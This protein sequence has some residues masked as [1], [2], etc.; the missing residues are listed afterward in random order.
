MSTEMISLLGFLGIFAAVLL[1]QPLVL[2]R[3]RGIQYVM[4]NRDDALGPDHPAVGRLART[5]SN[6]VEAAVLFIPLVLA[7]EVLGISNAL[8]QY[9][10]VAFLAARATYAVLYP[11]GVVGLRSLVW[12]AGLCALV[13]MAAGLIIA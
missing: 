6:N 3:A 8:T 1:A 4:G 10:A 13:A 12:N 9:G 11:L 7:T 2:A 5:V